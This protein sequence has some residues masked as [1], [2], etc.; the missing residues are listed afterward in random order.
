MTLKTQENKDFGRVLRDEQGAVVRIVEQRDATPAEK[1]VDEYNAGVYCLDK[2]LLFK[3]LGEI[4]NN[5]IQ[6]E[7]WA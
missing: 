3:A 2:D 5:N 1:T 4:D 6:K 7:C